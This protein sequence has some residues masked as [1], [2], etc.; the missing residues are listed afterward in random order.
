MYYSKFGHE[1][2]LKEDE[3]IAY[4]YVVSMRKWVE[5]TGGIKYYEEHKA[6]QDVEEIS[7]EEAFLYI[8]ENE[9]E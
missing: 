4:E 8:V 2:L 9:H 5:C 1:A 7:E 3:Y 6:C